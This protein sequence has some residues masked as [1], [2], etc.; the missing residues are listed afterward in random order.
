MAKKAIYPN[1]VRGGIAIPIP[2]KTNY[3]YMKGRKHKDGGIDIGSNPRTGIEV[4][5]GEVLHLTKNNVKVFSSLPFLNGQ[6]PAQKVLGGNNPNEVFKQQESFK[7]RNKINDDGTKKSINR[8]KA[9]IGISEEITEDSKEF[10]GP[11]TPNRIKYI[12]AVRSG[13]TNIHQKVLD[14]RNEYAQEYSIP[15]IKDKEIR[16]TKGRFN[17][18]KI[19]TNILDSIY[20]AAKRTNVPLDIALGLAGRESTLGIGR[21]FKE[22]KDISGT[23]LYS[24]WQQIQTVYNTNRDTNNY[25]K[26]VEKYNDINN[27]KNA[28][29]LLSEEEYAKMLEYLNKENK[30]FNSLKP[31]S[32]NPIDNA[33]KYF[34]TGKYNPGDKR[35]TQ[36]VK[37][38]GK[39]ILS[40]PAVRKWLQTKENNKKLMDGEKT[41]EE[42][43][44]T[45]PKEINDTTNYN[46]RRAY[47]TLSKDEL[48]NWRKGKGH[49]RSVIK[50]K[51]G[52][53]EF[54]KSK[55]HP[56]YQ[57]EIDWYNSDDAKSFREN[58][59]LDDST[60]YPKYIKR[61]KKA[62]GGNHYKPVT[63]TVN[64]K[65]KVMYSPS[66]GISRSEAEGLRHKGRTG[67]SLKVSRKEP[68]KPN[69]VYQ[70]NKKDP[71]DTSYSR[72]IEYNNSIDFKTFMDRHGADLISALGNITGG[73]VGYVGNHRALN[74]LQGPSQPMPKIATKLKTRINTAA[75]EDKMRESLAN[76][77][78]SV[79]SNTASSRVA[80]AR[81]QKARLNTLQSYNQ[82]QQQKENIE[83]ELINKDRLNRQSITN[84][85]ITD[86]NNFVDNKINFKNKVIDAKSENFMGLVNTINAGLQ[87]TITNIQKRNAYDQD[88][89]AI[90]AANPNVNPRYLKVLGI[91][92]ITN[93]MIRDWDKANNKSNR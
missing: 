26:L 5:D 3:Y 7:D 91:K 66:T 73:I 30:E 69:S 13:D 79:N 83:T 42:W 6:S 67:F 51:D 64:G 25:I 35:H 57:K 45:I 4:E 27:R 43:F 74:S 11:P 84:Q 76:Y 49:L 58:Y 92:G 38:D 46:L 29:R 40:D 16:L 72:P 65:T 33:L 62:M 85:N 90:M 78:R 36:M 1:I 60:E 75:S 39:T 93:K 44:K 82:L 61:T 89:L 9:L 10:V 14:K 20:N 77:E 23:D 24:N 88:R 52:N 34:M 32:E 86:Y 47:E 63:V 41:F 8:K 12:N 21:G 70:M 19:S 81:N 87:N 22:G 15:Y 48:E 37:D 71:I 53:Y 59:I 28:G 55:N 31:L 54:L 68:T 50:T 17:T 2:D 56:T 18:G 80:L